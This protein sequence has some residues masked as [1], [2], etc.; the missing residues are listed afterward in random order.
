MFRFRKLYANTAWCA[1][2]QT[3]LFCKCLQPNHSSLMIPIIRCFSLSASYL[4][5]P[6]VSFFHFHSSANVSKQNTII[7]SFSVGLPTNCSRETHMKL[8]DE[9]RENFID[10]YFEPN[11]T[12]L[13]NNCYENYFA[14]VEFTQPEANIS[15][16]E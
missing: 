11:T 4:I 8:I 2:V 12:Q 3:F 1:T 13:F 7:L 5:F 9:K 14:F 15:K 16:T 6:F 10:A